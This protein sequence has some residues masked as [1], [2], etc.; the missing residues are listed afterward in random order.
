MEKIE[1]FLYVNL[2]MRSA[3]AE[4]IKS[5]VVCEKTGDAYLELYNGVYSRFILWKQ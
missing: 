5:R 3:Y 4:R 2:C 1:G